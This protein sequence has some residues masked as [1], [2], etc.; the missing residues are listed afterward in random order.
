[1][2]RRFGARVDALTAARVMMSCTSRLSPLALA[3]VFGAGCSLFVQGPPDGYRPERDGAPACNRCALGTLT[4]DAIGAL[5][6]AG[7]A[8]AAGDSWSRG[9]DNA[10]GFLVVGVAGAVIHIGAFLAGWSRTARCRE[11]EDR[12]IAWA[13]IRQP[14]GLPLPARIPPP[15]PPNCAELERALG[16]ETSAPKRFDLIRQIRALCGTAPP[17]AL[18]D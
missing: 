16:V 15:L 7:V 2:G 4:L 12:F 17:G 3:A 5:G 13:Q 18:P 11:A 6:G 1:M 10:R 8:V 14:S 9:T